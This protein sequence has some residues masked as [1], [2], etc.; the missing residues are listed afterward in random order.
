MSEFSSLLSG[1]IHSKDI[2]TYALA[3]FCELDR[4]NMYKIINGKRK[5]TSMEMV[6]KMCRFMQLSPTEE[7]AMKE[8]Y[9][10]DLV[11][12]D[13]YYRRKNVLRFFSDFT[14]SQPSLPAA[15]YTLNFLED[16]KETVL[17]NSS[18]EI[19]RALMTI[20]T[21]ETNKEHGHIR[22]LVQPDYDFLMKI[23]TAQGF[24]STHTYIEHIICLNNS[25]SLAPSG[26]SYNLNSLEHI[27]PLYGSSFNYEC[28]YYY[29]NIES[30]GGMFTLFPYIVITSQY[31][32]MFTADLQHGLMTSSEE[33]IRM[34]CTIFSEYRRH[35]SPLFR[36]INN[37]STQLEYMSRL[38][39]TS[40]PVYSFQM[41]PCMTAFLTPEL[42]ERYIVSYLPERSTFIEM[43]EDY[44]SALKKTHQTGAITLFF[45]LEGLL[46]FMNTGR[47]GEY[48]DEVY[49]PFT[50][51]D[52]IYLLRQLI[53]GCNTGKYRML[54]NNIGN[55]NHQLFMLVS[56]QKGYLMFASP[57][58]SQ[59]IYLDIEEPSLLFAFLD[60]CENI[61]E[62]LIY[63]QEE[64]VN[65][66][67]SFMKNLR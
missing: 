39:S 60:F 64:T 61:D 28:F 23:L 2:R 22:M 37:V 24:S 46:N 54:K 5:P 21:L 66:L 10:I 14:L 67:R 19:D 17:L 3:Q 20:T 4:S 42:I 15:S 56:S 47:I 44:I 48:P 57:V 65:T 30:K 63:S 35:S 6:T 12:H 33:S 51:E 32:C 58:D 27:L 55:I 36:R 9:Q 11:G 41:T 16:T 31:A 59:F 26:K 7:L 62:S 40:A 18:S 1:H 52:R 49:S 45:S 13:N 34:F 43:L 25:S 53:L 29:D 8:A 50:Q 38:T